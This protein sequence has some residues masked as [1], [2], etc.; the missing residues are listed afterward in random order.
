MRWIFFLS[1]SPA[2]ECGEGHLSF[3]KGSLFYKDHNMVCLT[4]PWP[5]DYLWCPHYVIH[6]IWLGEEGGREEGERASGRKRGEEV[7]PPR[8]ATVSQSG[9][10][11]ISADQIQRCLIAQCTR[12]ISVGRYWDFRITHLLEGFL[13]CFY[14]EIHSPNNIYSSIH[15][16]Y[17]INYYKTCRSSFLHS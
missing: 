9:C 3:W 14:W 4:R 11:H 1:P 12:S 17:I 10:L 5:S 15:L 13:R 6:L 7:R 2:E 8:M 16:N